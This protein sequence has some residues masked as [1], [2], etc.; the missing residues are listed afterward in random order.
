M[1]NKVVSDLSIVPKSAQM[2]QD[3]IWSIQM[4]TFG[5]PQFIHLVS[6]QTKLHLI[7]SEKL[8]TI[9]FIYKK[10]TCNSLSNLSMK[11]HS[12]SSYFPLHH[13]KF[14]LNLSMTTNDFEVKPKATCLPK[15][16]DQI[17]V[18][19]TL[20]T[21]KFTRNMT[22][23]AFSESKWATTNIHINIIALLLLFIL[24]ICTFKKPQSVSR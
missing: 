16:Q 18:N 23:L 5:S 7:L 1:D 3:F 4:N 11:K 22:V 13:F 10:L 15:L 2:R 19:K 6:K 12:H 24:R 9:V 14:M 20:W 21:D 8:Y 17:N